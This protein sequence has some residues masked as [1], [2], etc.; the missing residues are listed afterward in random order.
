[1]MGWRPSIS[2]SELYLTYL[3]TSCTPISSSLNEVKSKTWW[4]RDEKHQAIK[5]L[6]IYSNGVPKSNILK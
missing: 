6:V 2:I 4:P 1:M 3:E 5:A